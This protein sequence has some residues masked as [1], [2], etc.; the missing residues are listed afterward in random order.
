MRKIL[1]VVGICVGNKQS[2]FTVASTIEAFERTPAVLQIAAFPRK[3]ATNKQKIG[4]C[5]SFTISNI[6]SA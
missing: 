6:V 4:L 5:H 2:V 3:G 1:P